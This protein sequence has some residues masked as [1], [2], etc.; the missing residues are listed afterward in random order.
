MH[1]CA[2][3]KDGLSYDIKAFDMYELVFK[4]I[5]RLNGIAPVEFGRH[6]N[7]GMQNAKCQ[8]RRYASRMPYF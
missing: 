3:C 8:W 5:L 4:Y 7:D 6:Q 1:A 2:E